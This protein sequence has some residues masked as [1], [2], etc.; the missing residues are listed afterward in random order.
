MNPFTRRD[1]LSDIAANTLDKSKNQ[2]LVE[3]LLE[4]T[5]N[6]NHRSALDDRALFYVEKPENMQVINAFIKRFL[7]GQ[8]L[9]P[10][11]RLNRL[12]LQLQTIGL[13]VDDG[14]MNFGVKDATNGT[15]NVYQYGRRASDHP[16]SGDEYIDDEIFLRSR[17]HGKLKIRTS[18]VPGGLYL[19][20]AELYMTSEK[21]NH[22]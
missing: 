3:A 11:D 18:M 2:T 13:H 7:T 21:K 15:F 19:I 4:S 10:M 17:M 22:D 14:D 1:S 8:H 12:F 5:Y 16:I 6:T 9:D 20:D